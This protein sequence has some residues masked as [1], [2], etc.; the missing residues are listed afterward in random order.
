MLLFTGK[1]TL[2]EA[3]YLLGHRDL[4]AQLQ[5]RRRPGAIEAGEALLTLDQIKTACNDDWTVVLRIGDL[6]QPEKK[7]AISDEKALA[8]VET[9]KLFL[10]ETGEWPTLEEARAFARDKGRK[11]TK[12]RSLNFSDAIASARE[13]L[14]AAGVS[15]PEWAPGRSKKRDLTWERTAELVEAEEAGINVRVIRALREFLD[16]CAGKQPKETPTLRY[17]KAL[18]GLPEHSH[19]PAGTT[20]QRRGS[21]PK[22]LKDARSGDA[23]EKAQALDAAVSAKKQAAQAARP[24]TSEHRYDADDPRALEILEFLRELGAPAGNKAIRAKCGLKKQTTTRLLAA[25][26]RAGEIEQ[27][28]GGQGRVYF[29]PA[30][31]KAA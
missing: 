12:P 21:W 22:L 27:S 3:D 24:K 16:L 26:V 18:R 11:L 28:G 6:P 19:W 15:S 20:V 7:A 13:E 29:I 31:E 9:L 23:L 1:K 17:Y 25:L 8:L 10:G 2:S 4:S 14:L 5:R 30:E